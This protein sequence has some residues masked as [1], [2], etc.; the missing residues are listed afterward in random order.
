M[1]KYDV[2]LLLGSR[3]HNDGTPDLNVL[4]RVRMAAE[5]WK[6]GVAPVI[7]ASG[8]KGFNS[9]FH[10]TTQAD[11]MA[12]FLIQ[13]GIPNE[14]IIREDKSETTWENIQNTKKLLG[15]EHFT[16]AVATSDTHMRRSLYMCK[17]QGVKAKGFPAQLPH[18]KQWRARRRMERLLRLETYVGWGDGEYPNWYRPVHIFLRKRDKRISNEAFEAYNAAIRKSEQAGAVKP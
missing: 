3:L 2:I 17:L 7:V 14:C 12:E 10:N 4:A 6:K 16:A 13:F 18:D 15:K 5:L 8:Y 1:E 11:V 9:E